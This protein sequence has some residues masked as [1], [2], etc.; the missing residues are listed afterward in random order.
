MDMAKSKFTTLQQ[1]C[2]L[3]PGHLIPKLAREHK[4]E[5]KWGG[6]DVPMPST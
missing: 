1:I 4:V 5:E 3:I 6:G 2:E